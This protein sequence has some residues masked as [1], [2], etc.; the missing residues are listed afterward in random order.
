VMITC[1][2]GIITVGSAWITETIMKARKR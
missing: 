1:I 2:L